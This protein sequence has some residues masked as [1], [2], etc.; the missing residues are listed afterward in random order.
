MPLTEQEVAPGDGPEVPWGSTRCPCSPSWGTQYTGPSS[1]VSKE[2]KEPREDQD[3][4]GCSTTEGGSMKLQF[5]VFSRS[6]WATTRAR[7]CCQCPSCWSPPAPLPARR[8]GCCTAPPCPTFQWVFGDRDSIPDMG[9]ALAAHPHQVPQPSIHRS[10]QPAM[11][12]TSITHAWGRVAVDRAARAALHLP[13]IP[14]LHGRSPAAQIK[15]VR[16]RR[17]SHPKLWVP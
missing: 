4:E 2:E 3:G 8:V 16:G 11:V 6:W 12:V 5:R 1:V 14:T 15:D 10:H 13:P 7:N 17:M 9:T